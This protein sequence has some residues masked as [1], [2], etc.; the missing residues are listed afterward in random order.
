MV[1][2]MS[3]PNLNTQFFSI[4]DHHHKHN[5]SLLWNTPRFHISIKK[6]L[7]RMTTSNVTRYHLLLCCCTVHDMLHSNLSI[8]FQCVQPLQESNKET[9]MA[10]RQTVVPAAIQGVCCEGDSLVCISSHNYP[11]SQVDHF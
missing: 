7:S 5:T 6:E 10:T 9:T 2:F 8:W 11:H 1:T 4:K 3:S